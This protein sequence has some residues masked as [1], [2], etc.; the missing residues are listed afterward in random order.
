MIIAK[1]QGDNVKENVDYLKYNGYGKIVFR[2]KED[3]YVGLLGT[4]KYLE[5]GD[6][7]V[8]KIYESTL[9]NYVSQSE[10]DYLA[11]N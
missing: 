9:S 8:L 4:K 3:L 2:L 1:V 10:L 11:R 6:V 5:L 7:E